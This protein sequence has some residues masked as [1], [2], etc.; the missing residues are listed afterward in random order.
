MNKE[1]TME[2]PKIEY[3]LNGMS[4]RDVHLEYQKSPL[5]RH[6]Q[7]LDKYIDYLE[8]Q[9]QTITIKIP[10]GVD[11]KIEVGY[12]TEIISIPNCVKIIRA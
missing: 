6:I 11:Y 4:L 7:L 9:T 2:R 5:F 1:E 10:K 3:S 12:E 8:S